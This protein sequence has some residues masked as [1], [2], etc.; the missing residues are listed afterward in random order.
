MQ[1]HLSILT[2][3]LIKERKKLFG[4]DLK[5]EFS[6]MYMLLSLNIVPELFVFGVYKCLLYSIVTFLGCRSDCGQLASKTHI[7]WILKPDNCLFH[8]GKNTWEGG[9]IFQKRSHSSFRKWQSNE[10]PCQGLLGMW[11][12]MSRALKGPSPEGLSGVL[13][14][15]KC[16]CTFSS[17]W[18]L[19]NPWSNEILKSM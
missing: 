1:V 3:C 13:Q 7:W 19:L 17:D 2:A 11:Q 4:D 10:Q 5:H 8:Q 12:D 14:Q 18:F 15:K 6:F 16:L 9:K